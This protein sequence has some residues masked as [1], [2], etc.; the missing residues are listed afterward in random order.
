MMFVVALTICHLAHAAEPICVQENVKK[1]FPVC[2]RR[3]ASMNGCDLTLNP[4][5]RG[6]YDIDARRSGHENLS[7]WPPGG[8]LTRSTIRQL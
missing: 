7:R 4:E 6:Y 8:F 5:G 3:R 2:Q 1:L